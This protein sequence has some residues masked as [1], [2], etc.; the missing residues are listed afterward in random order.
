MV[1]EMRTY[2]T[3]PGRMPNLQERFRTVTLSLFERHGIRPA[4]FW[5]VLVGPSNLDLIYLLQWNSMADR[6]QRW[7]AFSSDP[8]WVRERASSERDGP[9]VSSVSNMF[10]T[11][12]AFAAP[13]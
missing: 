6:E 8:E 10:L 1:Y 2:R 3:V 5:T 7:T 9:L 4:G 12:V 11:P 13:A